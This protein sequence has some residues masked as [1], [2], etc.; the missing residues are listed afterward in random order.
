MAKTKK[1]TKCTCC[2][3]ALATSRRVDPTQT[4][5]LRRAF[6]AQFY[7]R[8]RI[9]KG[10]ITEAIVKQDGFG[11]K[12]NIKSNRKFDFPRSSDKIT[13][14]MTWI[15]QMESQ[16]VLSV[17]E[18]LSLSAASE[19]AWTRLYIDSAYKRGL[20]SSAQRMRGQ[21]VQVSDA[22][23]ENAF[24]RPI[25]A[26]RI[27]L[28]YTRAFSDLKGITEV[29]DTQISRE[30]AQGLAE[31]R[32]P[33]DIARSINKRID[34]IGI[35]RARM[36]ARTEIVRSHA[37]ATLNAYAEAGAEGVNLE[38]EFLTAGDAK[39]CPVCRALEKRN[40]YK[41]S[42]ARGLIPAH[43]NAV[44]EGSTFIPYG[45]CKEIVRAWYS[46]PS[47]ILS[48]GG[49]RYGT[50][51]GPNHPMLTDRGMVK[52]AEIR[53]GDK[54]L[55]D[56]RHDNFSFSKDF[57]LKKVPRCEDVFKSFLGLSENVFISSSAS[58]LHG[59]RKFCQ[60]EVEAIRPA[61]S[62]LPKLNISILKEF[63]KNILMRSDPDPSLIS[64]FAP[65]DLCSHGVYLPSSCRIGSSDTGIVRDFV[66]VTVHN[67]KHSTFEGY[68]YD[69]TTEKG[70]Y[71][72]NG[73]VV[74]NCRCTFSPILKDP[75]KVRL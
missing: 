51:I 73:F 62:L 56:L 65:G 25:H 58:D 61:R 28:L 39:V 50:T 23:L 5:T 71:C 16:H 54:I 6:E 75:K 30:I 38:A 67:V 31:G 27:G 21:G 52:A 33:F 43:P 20:A 60:G 37:E 74:K 44:F 40:P 22:F 4:I 19:Q 34:K 68:A 64:S 11:L 14:F 35:T 15:K 49:G 24:F 48:C 66:W 13:A 69:Y 1:K 18:G 2:S 59:D 3:E 46:G 72:N 12:K 32:G 63:S 7:K 9:L 10:L 26:D 36:L 45:E 29:M 55:Y 41:L 53:E 57:N 8:F 17:S 47:V 70:L 42:Q